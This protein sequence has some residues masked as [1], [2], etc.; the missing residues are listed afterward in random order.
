MRLDVKQF[1]EHVE[2]KTRN[3]D[4]SSDLSKRFGQVL[5]R[6]YGDWI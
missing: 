3:S 4:K 6:H 1:Y 5:Q 2:I